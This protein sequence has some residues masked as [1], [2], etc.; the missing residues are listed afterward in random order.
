MKRMD[1][2][3]VGKEATPKSQKS[4]IVFLLRTLGEATSTKIEI[5]E[6]IRRL[7]DTTL[8]EENYGSIIIQLGDKVTEKNHESPTIS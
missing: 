8:A 3:D 5:E 2:T 4:K 7:T 1:A 6:A